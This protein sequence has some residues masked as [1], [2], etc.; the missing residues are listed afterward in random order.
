MKKNVQ[1]YVRLKLKVG[2]LNWTLCLFIQLFLVR[3]HHHHRIMEY[4]RW[5][6][7]G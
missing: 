3:R 1:L 4:R 2:T 7:D 6:P 5:E